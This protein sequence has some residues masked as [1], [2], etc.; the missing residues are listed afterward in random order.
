MSEVSRPQLVPVLMVGKEV[1]PLRRLVLAC[2]NGS[3]NAVKDWH[4]EDFEENAWLIIVQLLLFL[5]RVNAIPLDLSSLQEE[6]NENPTFIGRPETYIARHHCSSK[7]NERFDIGI[8][9]D[10]HLLISMRCEALTFFMNL[11]YSYLSLEI[12]TLEEIKTTKVLVAA[13]LRKGLY[14]KSTDMAHEAWH[15]VSCI[16][17]AI[18]LFYDSYDSTNTRLVYLD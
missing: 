4:L 14:K 9:F 10:L 17:M 8:E 15:I 16:Q 6:I 5:W 1:D 12:L 2:S 3:P 11:C 13:W 7:T 18:C